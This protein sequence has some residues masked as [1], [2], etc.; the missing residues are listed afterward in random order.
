MYDGEDGIFPDKYGSLAIWKLKEVCLSCS[1]VDSVFAFSL[2]KSRSRQ[3]ATVS[4]P[5]VS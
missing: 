4:D 5:V 1:F 2:V 3:K